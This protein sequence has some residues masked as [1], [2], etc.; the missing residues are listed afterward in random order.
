MKKILILAIRLYQ[1]TLSPDHSWLKHVTGGA[2]RY[3][4][5]CS[6]YMAAAIQQDGLRGILAGIRRISRCHPF[7]AGGY[8]PYRPVIK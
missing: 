7:V 6:E 8:D 3:E 4:P 2:C 5:T 1:Y